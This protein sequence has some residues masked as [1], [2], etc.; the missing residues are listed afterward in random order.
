MFIKILLFIMEKLSSFIYGN[1]RNI[2]VIS[3]DEQN[4][5]RVKISTSNNELKIIPNNDD[6]LDIELEK[7][8]KLRKSPTKLNLIDKNFNLIDKNNNLTNKNNNLIEYKIV[9]DN[10]GNSYEISWTKFCEDYGFFS[11]IKV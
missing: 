5:K 1:K 10:D 4:N 11:K 3:D 8:P 2:S 6:L 9:K 7:S